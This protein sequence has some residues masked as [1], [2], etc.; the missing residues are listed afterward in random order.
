MSNPAFQ[1]KES[2]QLCSVAT[3]PLVQL[4]LLGFGPGTLVLLVVGSVRLSVMTTANGAAFRISQ[5][6]AE[7]S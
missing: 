1:D 4:D 6:L 7:T 3:F 2:M 5:T